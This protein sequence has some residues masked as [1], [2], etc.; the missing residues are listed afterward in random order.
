M[1][2]NARLEHMRSFIGRHGDGFGRV[3]VAEG[4][5]DQYSV[6][7]IDGGFVYVNFSPR[8]YAEY[9]LESITA[10]RAWDLLRASGMPDL[11]L[12]Q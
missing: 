10:E 12:D 6:G 7:F 1:S 2:V 11:P 9:S 4:F 8:E 3:V 5:S